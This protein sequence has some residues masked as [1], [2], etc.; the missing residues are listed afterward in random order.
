MF[1]VLSFFKSVGKLISSGEVSKGSVVLRIQNEVSAE[2]INHEFDQRDATIWVHLL[3][4]ASSTCFE[5]CFRPSSGALDFI[6][7]IRQ[8]SPMSLPAGV[9]DELELFQPIHYTSQQPHR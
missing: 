3:F 5:R 7:S 1:S 4:L 8:Y 9:M 6:Y 2:I